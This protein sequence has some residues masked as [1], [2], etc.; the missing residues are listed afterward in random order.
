[1][2]ALLLQRVGREVRK[3]AVLHAEGDGDWVAADLAVF[4]VTL[5]ARGEIEQHRNLLPA[6]WA[7]EFVFFQGGPCFL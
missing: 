6:I 5:R 7:R 4:Y 2:V 3:L 1:M